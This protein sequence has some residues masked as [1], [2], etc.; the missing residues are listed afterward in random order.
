MINY[1]VLF[2]NNSLNSGDVVI[3]QTDPNI[4]VLNTLPLAWLTAPNYPNTRV[5]FQWTLQ[6]QFCWSET[7]RLAPGV[8]FLPAEIRQTDLQAMNLIECGAVDGHFAFF[9]QSDG[10]SMGSLYFKQNATVPIGEYSVG[11]GM[12]GQATFAVQ[13]QPNWIFALTPHPQYWIDFGEYTTGEALGPNK[14]LNSAQIEFPSG[15]Y[16]MTVVLN[17]DNTW[18]IRPTRTVNEKLLLDLE[19]NSTAKWGA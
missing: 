1:S 2:I 10:P 14:M 17:P 7:G 19:T 18:T 3:Y 5:S 12:S 6:Y 4:G 15:V 16:S 13:S 9:N 8:V 11:I